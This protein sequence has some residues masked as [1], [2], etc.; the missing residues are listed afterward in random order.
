ML[1]VG[2]RSAGADPGPA[3]YARGGTAPT[4]TDAHVVRGTIRPEAFLGGA[5]RLDAA[6]A[7]EAFREVAA[8]LG[9]D[10]AGA[11]AASI[12]LAVANIVRAIQLVSTERGRDPRDYA[13]VPFGGAGPLLAAEIAEELGVREIL[14]PPNPGVISAL[15]LIAADYMR[16]TGLTHRASLDAETPDSL[17]R[18]FANFRAGAEA[19]FRALGLHGALDFTVTA[20]MRF[21]GQAFEVPVELAPA[22]LPRLTVADLAEGFTA[23]H[24]RLYLH[25][26][27]A[28]RR[29]EV[30]GLRFGVRRKLEAMPAFRERQGAGMPPAEAKV[31]TASGPVSARLV[32]AASAVSGEALHG[33]ALI[34]SYSS[35][36]WVPPGWCA[37]P[38]AHGNTLLQKVTA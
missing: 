28:G 32:D 38:D 3:C 15:G 19:D 6:R 9:T 27:E 29:I 8:R 25:G 16:I 24:R 22:A 4:V 30:V 12:R 26:G 10:A 37:V 5:M 2:P 35:S 13:L 1:R 31:Q 23:A 20:D 34:E 11:A 33:P 21:V 36:T 17:R 7:H 18:A 14:V